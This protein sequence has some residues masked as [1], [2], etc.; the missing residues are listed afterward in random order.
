MNREIRKDIPKGSNIFKYSRQFIRSIENKL[1]NKIYKVL[2][3]K[4]PLEVL[5]KHRKRKNTPNSKWVEC[6][7]WGGFV[8]S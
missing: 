8:G 6:S 3:Y 1:Q 5:E 2:N 7:V 4:T